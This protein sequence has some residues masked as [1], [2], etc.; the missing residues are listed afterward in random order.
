MKKSIF[1]LALCAII[2][3]TVILSCD[4]STSAEKVEEA[5]IDVVHANNDLEKANEEYTA[6]M[7]GYKKD[8]ADKI[9]AND[10]IIKEFNERV[11][12]EK[13]EAKADYKKKI[14]ELEHKNTDMKKK[15]DE[16]KSDGKENWEKFKTEFNH[17]MEELGKSFKDFTVKN[18]K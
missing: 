3:G 10:L 18:T 9:T 4:S 15:L 13:K 12:K 14:D 8:I 17:D 1:A 7:A 2:T 11:S 6:D 5:K 16:Y